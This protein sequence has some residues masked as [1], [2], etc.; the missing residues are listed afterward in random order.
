MKKKASD[1]GR[2]LKERA[3]SYPG[4]WEDHPWGDTC[5][6]VNKKIFAFFGESG[7]TLKLA[8]AHEAAM[9]V[10]GATPTAYGMGKHGWVSIPLDSE[11]PPLPIL[12][13]WLD[14]SYRLVAPKKLAKRLDERT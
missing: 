11:L 14:E 5:V 12:Y 10:P 9:S 4:A 3:L 13:D 1:P 7:F 6:K 8:E 2:A